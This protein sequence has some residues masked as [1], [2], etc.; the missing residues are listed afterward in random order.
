MARPRMVTK[1]LASI[2][3]MSPVS[4][5]PSGGGS[6]TPGVSA[7]KISQHDIGAFDDEAAAFGD[8]FD[9]LEA[10]LDAVEQAAD[11][12]GLDNASAY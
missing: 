1:P 3:T 8:A 12:A 6:M 7:R 10:V 11:G 2:F 5:Q 4:Y 9:R